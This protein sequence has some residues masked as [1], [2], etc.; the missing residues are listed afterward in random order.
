MDARLW[1]GKPQP[2]G[3]RQF[4]RTSVSDIVVFP[5]RGAVPR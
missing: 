5:A 3:G 4:A 1:A 2:S